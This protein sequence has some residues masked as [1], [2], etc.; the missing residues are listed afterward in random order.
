MELAETRAPGGLGRVEEVFAPGRPHQLS[1]RYKRT[2]GFD[3]ALLNGRPSLSVGRPDGTLPGTE[4]GGKGPIGQE[5]DA[6]RDGQH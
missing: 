1:N 3:P 2:A 4:G 6:G 5:R